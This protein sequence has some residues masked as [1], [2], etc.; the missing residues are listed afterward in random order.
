MMSGR[1][2][3]AQTGA[4]R[5]ARATHRL[6]KTRGMEHCDAAVCRV[7][8]MR[9]AYNVRSLS[10]ANRISGAFARHVAQRWPG[11]AEVPMTGMIREQYEWA[12]AWC[13]DA[14]QTSKRFGTWDCR[15]CHAERV[16]ILKAMWKDPTL[17]MNSRNEIY[18][19]CRHNAK[20]HKLVKS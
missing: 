1:R 3:R 9:G 19:T 8:W 12:T 5:K 6:K 20:I 13:G 7:K 18:G 16:T 4:Q 14:I 10:D 17:V 15:L 11:N 2:C